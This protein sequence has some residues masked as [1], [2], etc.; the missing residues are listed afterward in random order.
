MAKKRMIQAIN[1][2]LDGEMAKDPKVVV[3]GEDVEISLFGDT[4][5][6]KDKHGAHRVR[7]MPISE[8]VMS[9]MAVGA[10]AA[11]YKV[12]CHMMFGNF[13]YTGF[14]SIANQASKL[15]YMT[16][17]QIALPIVYMGVFGGGR[18]AAAQHSDAMHPMIM[19]LGGIKVALPATPADAMGLL[20]SAIHDPNPVMFLQAAGRGGEQ[21]EVPEGDHVIELG[22]ASTVLEGDDVTVV[23]IGAM[24]RPAM[25]AAQEL[26][27]SGIGVDLIDP[28][29]VVPLDSEMILESVRKTGRLVVVD[30]ARDMCSAASHIAAICA[31]QCFDA[32][33]APIRRVTV[34]DVALPYSPPL[35]KALLP[36]V[37]SISDAVHRLLGKA[38]TDGS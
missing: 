24:V 22:K 14:D 29:T 32:L 18:S 2:A 11:G 27:K 34:P 5:G 3:F 10:A 12:V 35:E 30:E 36:N 9:G 1:E 25:R 8:T 4:R 31:D 26:A 38:G 20:R 7:N 13:M 16:A 21:G 37:A 6:L 17:G 23:A 15:R 33:R 28:R 19:N